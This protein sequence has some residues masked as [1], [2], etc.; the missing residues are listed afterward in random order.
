MA[1][2]LGMLIQKN[3]TISSRQFSDLLHVSRRTIL[4]DLKSLETYLQ[5]FSVELL[6]VKNK[7]FNVNGNEANIRR[8]YKEISNKFGDGMALDWLLNN[9]DLSKELIIKL[10]DE[11]SQILYKH[12]QQL[13][14]IALQGLLVHITIAI[15][16]LKQGN[17]ISMPINQLRELREQH[18]ELQIAKEITKAMEFITGLDVPE[19]EAGF[20][21][22]HLLGAKTFY[23][24][25]NE[26]GQELTEATKKL[27]AKVSFQSGVD[28]I[29][30]ELLEQGLLV[31]LKPAIY[32]LR[33]HLGLQNPMKS[34][35]K[36]E[37][38][39]LVE[40]ISR[41][42]KMLEREFAVE[43]NE[44][45]ICYIALHFRAATER[46]E[47]SGR[48][49]RVLLVC[50]SGV[51]TVQLLKSRLNRFF[52]DII[53]VASI[54]YHELEKDNQDF[55]IDYIISTV[56]IHE[57]NVPSIIVNPFLAKEDREKISSHLITQQETLLEER[58]S[59]PVLEEVLKPELIELNVKV[60]KWETAVQKGGELLV[61][62]GDVEPRYVDAMVEM[63]KEHGPYV[64]LD[65]GVA[66]PHARP[67]QGVNHL[68]LSLLQLEDPIEFGHETNDPVHLIICLG[69]IDSETHLNA[70]RQLIMLLNNK[71][72][73]D[74][75]IRG[76]K[77][78]IIDVIRKA[79]LQ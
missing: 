7:G 31:H 71:E 36:Q 20:I 6:Y 54:P 23:Q 77:Q 42:I 47:I 48:K 58:K 30:D 35:I 53:V 25:T 70:L 60:D 39:R 4:D 37:Y 19:D 62:S 50:G 55:D 11:I 33:Y 21:T 45:E 43:F 44:E 34:Y 22:L 16:R 3:H 52:P 68:C 64:V 9:T 32:R 24:S 28:F 74:I 69:S 46:K 79:S 27:I 65:K 15:Q 63:V 67:N 17:S 59:G 1:T 56:P 12:P 5:N 49:V 66:M 75:L 41:N 13:T 38:G 73:K 76:D 61:R 57:N 40:I 78:S 8:S 26:F 10:Q 72:S 51:G 14:D 18:R 2:I 29:D